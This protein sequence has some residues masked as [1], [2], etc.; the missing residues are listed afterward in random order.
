MGVNSIGVKAGMEDF[1]DRVEAKRP[2]LM[3]FL[4]CIAKFKLKHLQ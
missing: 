2:P 1:K 4:R 3:K